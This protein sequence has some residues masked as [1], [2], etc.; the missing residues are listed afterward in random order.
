MRGAP[1]FPYCGV[2]RSPDSVDRAL[3]PR[4]IAAL[5]HLLGDEDLWVKEHARSRL[6]A[7]GPAAAPFLETARGA[8]AE[9]AVRAESEGLLREIRLDAIER[10]W[11]ALQAVEEGVA[12]REG[13]FL[14]ERL[15]H[16]GRR[17][18]Q[19][20]AREELDQIVAGAVEAV[21]VRGPS[22]VRLDALRRYIHGACGFRG[23]ADDYYDAEN[24]FLSSVIVRRTGIPITLALIYLEVGRR[25]GLSLVGVGMP[26]HFLVARRVGGALRYL[27]PFHGGREVS[28]GECLLLL[29]RAGYEPAEEYLRPAPVVAILERMARNLIVIY[30]NSSLDRE[31]ALARRY[32]TMLTGEVV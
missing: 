24:S 25:V 6:R 21:P 29:E 14:L 4:D 15:I 17:E 18:R 13:A 16:P 10:D 12:L 9:P 19:A 5:I 2:R 30:Q 28:H 3:T 26:M 11:V 7:A 27:D 1:P 20:A 22:G 23:N 8:D 32:V 31:L